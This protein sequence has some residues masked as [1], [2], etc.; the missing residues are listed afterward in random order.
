[1]KQYLQ[2]KGFEA[3]LIGKNAEFYGHA[4][5]AIA[6]KKGFDGVKNALSEIQH[7]GEALIIFFT[8][9]LLLGV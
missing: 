3:L 1:M 2:N 6:G 7:T 5:N 8:V 9:G 4:I